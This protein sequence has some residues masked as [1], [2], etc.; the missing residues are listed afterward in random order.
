M[1]FNTTSSPLQS[2][3]KPDG[4][5]RLKRPLKAEALP[6]PTT[7][8]RWIGQQKF[9]GTRMILIKDNK[10]IT[11]LV[12][13]A[14]VDK[15]RQYPELV[16]IGDRLPKSTIVDGEV[17]AMNPKGYEEFTRVAQRD[18][19]K[20]DADIEVRQ[21]EIP[22]QFRAFDLLQFGGTDMRDQPLSTRLTKLKTISTKNPF[23]RIATEKNIRELY[24]KLRQDNTV[25]GIIIK[26][27]DSKYDEAK[28]VRWQKVKFIKEADVVITGFTEGQGKRKGMVGALYM[29]VRDN[30]GIRDLGKV[31]TGW[32]EDQAREMFQHLSKKIRKEEE[33]PKTVSRT[34]SRFLIK[35]EVFAKVEYLKVGSRG[36]LREPSFKGLRDDITLADTHLDESNKELTKSSTKATPVVDS[37]K[38][39]NI[40]EDTLTHVRKHARAEIGGSIR[41]KDQNPYDIDIVASLKKGKKLGDLAP[42]DAEVINQ[43]KSKLTLNNKGVQI[44][45]VAVPSEVFGAGLMYMTGPSGYNIAYRIRAKKMGY[46]LSQY[47][48]FDRE[49]GKLVAGKT[50]RSIYEA[51]DKKYKKPEER[52]K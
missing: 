8:V 34:G 48:L 39:L 17:I 14:G 26:Q 36:S 45:I 41:R 46:K 27:I 18:K 51:L 28:D 35:P 12:N 24:N 50:E 30:G 11:H 6:K 31:G 15:T 3:F 10:G 33:V 49:S 16:N 4:K 25:E 19:L 32:S 29:G 2:L 43:G 47:G 21:K 13:R 37:S 38:V 52:G 7:G 42:P 5:P 1:K 44:D 9:D 40:A 22:V 23:H 20:S